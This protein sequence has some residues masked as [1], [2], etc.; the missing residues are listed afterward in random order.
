MVRIPATR[1]PRGATRI[2]PDSSV[3]RDTDNDSIADEV[4]PGV[5]WAQLKDLRVAVN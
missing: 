4:L 3:E 1:I 2:P 5:P